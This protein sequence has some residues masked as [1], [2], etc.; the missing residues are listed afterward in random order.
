MTELSQSVGLGGRARKAS[1]TAEK[2]RINVRKRLLDA[3][4][5][6][7]EHSPALAKHL[8]RSIKTGMFCSYDP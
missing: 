2:A 4:V 3:L 6:I 5:R 8:R 7:G 1:S